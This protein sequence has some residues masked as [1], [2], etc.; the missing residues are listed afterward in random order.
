MAEMRFQG[1]RQT[2]L[3]CLGLRGFC[4]YMTLGAKIRKAL[5][6]LGGVYHLN[7]KPDSKGHAFK[8]KPILKET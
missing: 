3:I 1:R 8:Q 4:E 2:V 6:K 7:F 5:S